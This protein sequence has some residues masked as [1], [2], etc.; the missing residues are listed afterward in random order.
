[1][2]CYNYLGLRLWLQAVS[3]DG[4]CQARFDSLDVRRPHWP[5]RLD[6]AH[7]IG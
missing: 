1:M 6:C 2:L 5:L 3:G 7:A 4:V